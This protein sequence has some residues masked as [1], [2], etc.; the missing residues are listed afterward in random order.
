MTGREGAAAPQGASDAV[1]EL[2]RS[3]TEAEL[4]PHRALERGAIT[5]AR[6]IGADGVQG[7]LI[8][9]VSG[10]PQLRA[11][12]GR[13]PPDATSSP[14]DLS[15]IRADLIVPMRAGGRLVGAIAFHGEA[16][17]QLDAGPAADLSVGAD[18]LGMAVRT[19]MLG[20]GLTD[21]A[22]ELAARNRRVAALG[23]IVVAPVQAPDPR[24]AATTIAHAVRDGL[25]AHS[26]ELWSEEDGRLR[27]IARAPSAEREP[28]VPAGL[29]DGTDALRDGR[30]CAALPT[31]EQAF[32]VVDAREGRNV[33]EGLA[34]FATQAGAALIN[35]RL[36]TSLAHERDQRRAV[37]AAL[38]EAQDGER[39]RIAE[40]VHDGPVQYLVALALRLEALAIDLRQVGLEGHAHRADGGAKEAREAVQRL[41]EAIFDLHPI[42]SEE[43]TLEAA[44]RALARRLTAAG[45]RVSRLEVPPSL[46]VDRRT[47]AVGARVLNESVANIIRHSEADSV[48]I[49]IA[50]DGDE[51]QIMVSDDGRGFVE[52]D[53][54]ERLSHGHL[55]LLS[56]RQRVEVAGG[57]LT[58]T[59]A[60]GEGTELVAR[61]P[62]TSSE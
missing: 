22:H 37:G 47:R 11:S 5:L 50:E 17:R 28:S 35:A 27:L 45:H 54:S 14:T 1:A 6:A 25:A 15:E 40:D 43:L 26:V 21:R 30:L 60:P 51:I 41:R 7:Y 57:Q 61:L 9:G 53:V 32:L 4:R 36:S 42:A 52:R 29:R 31:P 59:S 10:S 34:D 23:K 44:A 62:L 56:L 38:I 39:R 33:S 46:S 8:E 13:I 3:W 12:W 19:A 48:E 24:A 20:S 18:L 2:I 49:V 58:I 16:L 55:G